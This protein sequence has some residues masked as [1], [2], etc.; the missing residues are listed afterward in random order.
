M[1]IIL[2]KNVLEVSRVDGNQ[3]INIKNY[4]DVSEFS[5]EIK[6]EEIYVIYEIEKSELLG[7]TISQLSK[8]NTNLFIA[9]D[10]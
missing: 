5:K 4:D 10:K 8:K 6:D 9:L 2:K 3:V 1:T 7:D